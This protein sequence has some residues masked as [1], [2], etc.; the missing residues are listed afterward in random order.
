[1]PTWNS[2]EQQ[3]LIGMAKSSAESLLALLND[4]LDFSKIEAG[5]LDLELVDFSLRVNLESSVKGLGLRARRRG[6]ELLCDIPPEVPDNLRGDPSRLRQILVNLIGNAIKFTSLGEVLVRVQC[7]AETD[8][9][10][11]LELT[12]HDTSIGIS[13]A[14]QHAIFESFTQADACM[15]RKYGG[16]GLGLAICKSLVELMNGSI[17][18][19]SILGQGS[20][21]HFRL[22]FML[23]NRLPDAAET[24]DL[25]AIP[26]IPAWI[27][28][29]VLSSSHDRAVVGVDPA[30]LARKG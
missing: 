6:L 27:V 17:W 7:E 4:I 13:A 24:I 15:T 9:S 3:E 16:N 23:Q 2:I 25:T 29:S 11:T 1:V 20:T 19:E 5:K 14:A 8:D 22:P 28:A 26:E 21:F 10:A 30:E 12:V 18:V